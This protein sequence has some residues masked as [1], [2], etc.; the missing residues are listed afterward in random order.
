MSSFASATEVRISGENSIFVHIS[1]HIPFWS[2]SFYRDYT[3][4]RIVGVIAI[5]EK[6][7]RS[8][9]GSFADQRILAE[10]REPESCYRLHFAYNNFCCV[11]SSLHVTPSMES[12]LTD[13]VWTI[14]EL[15]GAA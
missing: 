6:A 13:H 5:H 8:Q 2:I 4:D 12:G 1:P 7:G 9:V 15:L 3:H 11:H 14:A 10:T